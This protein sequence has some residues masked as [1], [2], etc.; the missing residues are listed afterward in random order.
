MDFTADPNVQQVAEAYA[1]DAVD[2]LKNHYRVSL[3]WSD[4]S[5]R[6]IET[7][8]ADMYRQ[9]LTAKPTEDAIDGFSKL[10]GYYVG[11]VFR[12]NHGATWGMIDAGQGPFTG[13]RADRSKRLFWP[14]GRARKRLTEGPSEDMWDY[15]VYCCRESKA[16]S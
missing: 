16:G 8:M 5:I 10:F 15:Y 14:V 3:D 7:A 2:F 12:K 4:A 11:E 13:L 6:H 1:L 9:S